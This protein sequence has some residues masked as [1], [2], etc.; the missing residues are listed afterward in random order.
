LGDFI[1]PFAAVAEEKGREER[2]TNP[3][4][5]IDFLSTENHREFSSVFI[6]KGEKRAREKGEL[7]ELS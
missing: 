5:L 3:F 1:V 4:N 6:L 7:L 2:K